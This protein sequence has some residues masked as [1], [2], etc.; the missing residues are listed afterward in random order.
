MQMA[1]DTLRRLLA[2][3]AEWLDFEDC[4]PVDWVVCGG[5][6][7]MLQGL[8]SRT[9]RD[10]DVLG[11]W[12]G[13]RMEIV[14]TQ[15]F[16]HA[17]KACIRKVI[18]NHPEMPDLREKFVNMGPSQLVKFGLPKGF[19]Q[20]LTAVQF[21]PKLTLH[22]LSRADLLP[23]KLYAAS[24]PLGG[25][26][27]V[28]FRDLQALRPTFTELD[29]AVDWMRGLADFEEKKMELKEVVRRLDHEDL[30]YYI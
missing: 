1:T 23:L 17:V 24:D 9:T 25:R 20:R 19:E 3:L 10:V 4:D 2:E 27:E 15:D 30:A 8:Q 18:E 21:G 6:A 13:E 26:Q 28:H 22:L 11:N 7:L 29:A 5:T 16:S 12:N 14:A